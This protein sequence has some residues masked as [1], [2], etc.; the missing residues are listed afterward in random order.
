MVAAHFYI[1]VGRIATVNRIFPGRYFEQ[2]FN[3]FWRI[4][5]ASVIIQ[6]APGRFRKLDD[7]WRRVSNADRLSIALGWAIAFSKSNRARIES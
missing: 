6:P 4:A 2:R 1:C 5:E 3:E 7:F